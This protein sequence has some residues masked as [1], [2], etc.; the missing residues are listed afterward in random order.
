[1]P[2]EFVSYQIHL[3]LFLEAVETLEQQRVVTLVRNACPSYSDGPTY[4]SM[5]TIANAE[6]MLPDHLLDH[7]SKAPWQRPAPTPIPVAQEKIKRSEARG[8]HASVPV[9]DE[10]VGA[11]IPLEA[12]LETILPSLVKSLEDF[13]T[14]IS[15]EYGGSISLSLRGDNRADL[16]G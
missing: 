10:R 15:V 14:F 13:T 7:V 12:L 8:L 6:K 3:N 11:T 5:L 4:R 2:L 1:M 16:L 9:D